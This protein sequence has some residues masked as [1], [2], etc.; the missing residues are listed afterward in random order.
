MKLIVSTGNRQGNGPLEAAILCPVE[1][2]EIHEGESMR[3]VSREALIRAGFG[4]DLS[5]WELKDSAGHIVP[6][7][8]TEL[9]AGV[10]YLAIHRR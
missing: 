1:G 3:T 7:D 5:N 6:F 9:Q 10:Q 2:F 4:S 8:Q